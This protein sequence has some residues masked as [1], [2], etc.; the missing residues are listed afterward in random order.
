MRKSEKTKMFPIKYEDIIEYQKI[1]DNILKTKRNFLKNMAEKLEEKINKKKNRSDC[2]YDYEEKK[3]IPNFFKN[4]HP[5][6]TL[7]EYTACLSDPSFLSK[8]FHVCEECFLE[9]TKFM[10]LYGA[11]HNK[12]KTKQEILTEAFKLDPYLKYIY[13]NSKPSYLILKHKKGKK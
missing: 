7:H 1:F 2:F 12:F 11:S 8:N 5:A 3:N 9:I 4:I 6:M 10:R 13:V